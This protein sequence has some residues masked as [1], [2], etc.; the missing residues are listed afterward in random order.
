MKCSLRLTKH[1]FQAR[2]R[3]TVV[4]AVEAWTEARP[5]RSKC[6]VLSW[7]KERDSECVSHT[8]VLVYEE[9]SFKTKSVTYLKLV[10]DWTSLVTRRNGC[11]LVNHSLALRLFAYNSKLVVVALRTDTISKPTL[12]NQLS[13]VHSPTTTTTTTTTTTPYWQLP[14]KHSMYRIPNKQFPTSSPLSS[15]RRI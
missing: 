5:K 13:A 6:T 2:C 9:Y 4:E 8:L 10:R 1:H 15:L 11:S 7:V 12:Y 3:W 14:A